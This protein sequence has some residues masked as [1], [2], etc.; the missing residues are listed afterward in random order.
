LVVNPLDWQNIQLLKAAGSGEYFLGNVFV[1]TEMG[2]MIKAP[3][4]WGLPVVVTKSTPAG[5]AL[6]G[7]FARAAQLFRREGVLIEMSNSDGDN[8]TR[9]LVTILAE[10]RALVATYAPAAFC[11]CTG[12]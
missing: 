12:L 7:D 2:G 11:D 8:F 4:L 6:V 10:L 3:S 1:M 9:N 5:T